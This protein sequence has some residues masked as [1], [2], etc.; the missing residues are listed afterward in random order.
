MAQIVF[1]FEGSHA[2]LAEYRRASARR[3]DRRAKIS[4]LTPVFDFVYDQLGPYFL[5]Y[6]LQYMDTMCCRK[7]TDVIIYFENRSSS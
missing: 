2:R 6:K 4:Y 3:L 5:R 1:K 7:E